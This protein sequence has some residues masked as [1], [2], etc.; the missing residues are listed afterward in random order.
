MSILKKVRILTT[1]IILS[2]CVACS[3]SE[4][5]KIEKQYEAAVSQGKLFK[6][7]ELIDQLYELS[8]DSFASLYDQKN[9]LLN[10]IEEIHANDD[11]SLKLS[12]S[13]INRI[14]DFSP[15]YR[16]LIDLKEAL[17]E[18]EKKKEEIAELTI[19]VAATYDDI[20]QK[21]AN[22]PQHIEFST[23]ELTIPSHTTSDTV[24]DP[25]LA[26]LL[27]S[28]ENKA[29]NSYQ[30]DSLLFGLNK[31]AANNRKLF[32]LLEH[33]QAEVELSKQEMISVRKTNLIIYNLLSSFYSQQLTA[34]YLWI[35][36]QNIQLQSLI[37][38]ALGIRDMDKFWQKEYVPTATKIHQHAKKEYME[39]LEKINSYRLSIPLIEDEYKIEKATAEEINQFV[40]SM[41]WPNNSIYEF[42]EQSEKELIEFKTLAL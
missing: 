30:F 5:S 40:N 13:Q 21:L 14:I 12:T 24:N 16:L 1:L 8:P 29:L 26:Q 19:K 7:I 23:K 10:L 32:N 36:Q 42:A 35:E 2:I 39:N 6:Q 20:Q 17:S 3:Q 18:K 9:S 38:T 15:N 33:A 41:L 34:C 25:K 11:K 4:V 22:I 37:R 31:I 28:W 27:S